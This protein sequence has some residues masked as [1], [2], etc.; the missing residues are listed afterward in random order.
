MSYFISELW[1]SH[2]A[3]ALRLAF[4]RGGHAAG[5][6][7]Q[8]CPP[9]TVHAAQHTRYTPRCAHRHSLPCAAHRARS[10]LA[11]TVQRAHCRA[12]TTRA[13]P[14]LICDPLVKAVVAAERKKKRKAIHLSAAD[15]LEAKKIWDEY[16]KNITKTPPLAVAPPGARCCD[17]YEPDSFPIPLF[18]VEKIAG[19]KGDKKCKFLTELSDSIRQGLR[20][21]SREVLMPKLYPREAGF[22][23][24]GSVLLPDS[25]IEHLAMC[26]ERVDTVE[27][28]QRRARWFL[29]RDHGEDLYKVILIKHVHF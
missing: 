6:E 12:Q 17:V 22:L 28:L 7:I 14:R 5:P 21:W 10:R 13:M 4:P 20:K 19:L 26:G 1:R 24:T 2:A 27:A 16:F 23:M 11:H 8:Q 15:A 3:R 18:E 25:T 29:M 9:T